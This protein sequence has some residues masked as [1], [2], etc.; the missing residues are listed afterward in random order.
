[1]PGFDNQTMWAANVDFSDPTATQY[2]HSGQ[3]TADGQ[4]MIGSAVAPYIR[5]ATLSSSGG[6]LI[7]NGAGTINIDGAGAGTPTTYQANAGTATPAAYILNILGSGAITT[8]AAGNTVTISGGGITWSNIAV[9]QT[10]AV[11]NGYFCSGGAGLSLALPAVSAVGDAIEV[12]LIGSTSFTITQSAG[13][14]IRLGATSTTP[15]V[16]GSLA[17]TQQG[18]AIRMIC[19]TANLVWAIGSGAIGNLTVV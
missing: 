12:I 17:S 18:D 8:A 2:S 11:N 4:L 19:Q 3:I 9:N 10:L 13:Q 7:T 16:G 1:M 15:G 6:I 5:I 14:S